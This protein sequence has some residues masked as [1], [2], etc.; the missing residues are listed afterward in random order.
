MFLTVK[1]RKILLTCCR[2]LKATKE[3][4]HFQNIFKMTWLTN[5]IQIRSFNYAAVQIS[6]KYLYLPQIFIKSYCSCTVEYNISRIYDDLFIFFTKSQFRLGEFTVDCYNF[7]PKI[8]IF[9][10]QSVK[11]LSKEK[12]ILGQYF[13]TF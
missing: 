12:N 11:K 3:S 1:R 2:I 9:I 5:R 6:Y 7:L 10:S 8:W 13:S 4:K